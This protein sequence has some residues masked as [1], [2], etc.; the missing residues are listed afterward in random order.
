M[1]SI[2]VSRKAVKLLEGLDLQERAR[3][4]KPVAEFRRLLCVNDEQFRKL[5]YHS[6]ELSITELT[7]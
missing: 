2:P 5:P 7:I 1:K 3:S 6:T 4:T